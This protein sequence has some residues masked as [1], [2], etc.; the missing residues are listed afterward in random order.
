VHGIVYDERR[1]RASAVRVIDAHSKQMQELKA[2]VIFLC[3]SALA[4]THI[5]LNSKSLRFPEG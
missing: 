3:A 4:S 5:L 1:G 2:R